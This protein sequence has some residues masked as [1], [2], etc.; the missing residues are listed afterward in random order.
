MITND[1]KE[2]KIKPL[3]EI[4]SPAKFD[5]KIIDYLRNKIL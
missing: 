2:D 1:K 4:N 5:K 3:S